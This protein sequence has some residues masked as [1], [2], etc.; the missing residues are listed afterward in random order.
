[1]FSR[2]VLLNHSSPLMFVWFL[3]QTESRGTLN[4]TLTR[5]SW[6]C[7]RYGCRDGLRAWMEWNCSHN[8][9]G[10]GL[11][12]HWFTVPL[13]SG[14]GY[15]WNFPQ[16]LGRMRKWGGGGA[17]LSCLLYKGSS[18]YSKY[19]TQKWILCICEIVTINK[20][21]LNCQKKKT[22]KPWIWITNSSWI[23]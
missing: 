6:N 13:L 22:R 11:A 3:S 15:V 1:M 8:S 20:S 18:K 12:V 19:T 23:F 10:L 16:G 9:T 14:C 4:Q 2:T 7:G 17:S 5:T 21:P